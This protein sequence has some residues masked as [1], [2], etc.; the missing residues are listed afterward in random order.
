MN[1]RNSI[2][3]LFFKNSTELNKYVVAKSSTEI[4]CSS[5]IGHVTL[6]LT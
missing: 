1:K 2:S 5:N 4:A 3:T 6:Q